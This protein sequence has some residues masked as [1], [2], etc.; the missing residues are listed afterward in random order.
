MKAEWVNF[1]S[2][3]ARLLNHDMVSWFKLAVWSL[4]D[5]LETPP[6]ENLFDCDVAAA[7]Q[8]IIHSGDLLFSVLEHDEEEPEADRF[9][10]GPLW[11]GKGLLS[12]PR[13]G[14]WKHRFSEIS[15]QETGQTRSAAGTARMKMDEIEQSV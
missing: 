1:N 5:A 8:W 9:W 4:R 11:K 6:R 7:A 2:F 14:F 10:S 15:E 3:A 12:V 13:W